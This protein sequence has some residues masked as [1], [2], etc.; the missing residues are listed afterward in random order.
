ME[1]STANSTF[2]GLLIVEYSY[3]TGVAMSN[4][5]ETLRRGLRTE[6]ELFAHS[7]MTKPF[8]PL[9]EHL[10]KV[11]VRAATFAG[12]F[13]AGEWGATVGVW[14]DLGKASAAFQEYIRQGHP[15]AT[16]EG[17]E[18]DDPKRR[19][20]PD[21]A[22]FG[23]RHAATT[24]SDITGQILAFCIAGHH[25]GLADATCDD[26]SMRRSTLQNR[27]D[28]SRYSIEPIDAA[29]AAAPVSSLR[30]PFKLPAG[31]G[32][33][34]SVAFF[35]RMLFSC[36]IDADR[37]ETEAFCNPQQSAERNQPKPSLAQLRAALDMF[38]A[39]KQRD[40]LPTRVNGIRAQVL[41]DCLRAA[42]A[43]SGF[44]FA[45]RAN[46]RRQDVCVAGFCAPPRRP[47]YTASARHRRDS[48]YQHH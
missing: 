16:E 22:T 34:F 43:P 9:A 31:D 23:A 32:F 29:I 1:L 12:A 20:G 8:E 17:G 19:R 3:R 10:A 48:V 35:T 7:S 15:D 25:A 11:S 28:P 21:H 33:G 39:E 18:H 6:T 38:L 13:G 30:P 24:F 37:L 45:E 27:L 41:A 2:G 47:S 14:H 46:R 26:E 40:A 44:F 5:D 42:A 36:L 4:S